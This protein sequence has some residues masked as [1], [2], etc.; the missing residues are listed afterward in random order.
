[1]S[2][3]VPVTGSVLPLEIVDDHMLVVLEDEVCLI[4]TGAPVSMGAP[5]I[6]SAE[7]GWRVDRVLGMDELG[8]QAVL[9]DWPGRTVTFGYDIDDGDAGDV[10]P[11]RPRAGLYQIEV[12]TPVGPRWAFLDTGAPLSYGSA[13]AC[14]G[15]TSIGARRDFHPGVGVFTVEQYRMAVGIG[16]RRFDAVFG[17]LPESLLRLLTIVGSDGWIIGSDVFRDRRV[18]LDFPN[19]R[20]VDLGT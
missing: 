18:V 19:D 2:D 8:R 20:I 10:I 12:A 6:V 17:V 1:M 13:R 7:L 5:A 11:A 15:L 16:A 4:D 14:A 9:L 3:A